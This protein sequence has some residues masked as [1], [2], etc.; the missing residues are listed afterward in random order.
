MCIPESNNPNSQYSSHKT[1]SPPK[2]LLRLSHI[3]QKLNVLDHSY[4]SIPDYSCV[5]ISSI[6]LIKISRKKLTAK[7]THV[8]STAFKKGHNRATY[9]FSKSPP[10]EVIFLD[11]GHS[12][13]A[14]AS[15]QPCPPNCSVASHSS[16]RPSISLGESSVYMTSFFIF[17]RTCS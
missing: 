15:L 2:P 14:P 5:A 6:S 1:C 11:F 10:P 4:N 16:S 17:I 7:K 12:R 8:P 3:I 13:L 9:F